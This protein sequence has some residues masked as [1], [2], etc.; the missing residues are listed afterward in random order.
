MN[1]IQYVSSSPCLFRYTK[2]MKKLYLKLNDA[3][4]NQ[5]SQMPGRTSEH[6]LYQNFDIYLR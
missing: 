2:Q 5:I 1:R 3:G 4:V 6:D